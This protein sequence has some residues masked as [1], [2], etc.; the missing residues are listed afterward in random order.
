MDDSLQAVPFTLACCA[1]YGL[2]SSTVHALCCV[3]L[4]VVQAI[5]PYVV[6]AVLR[7]VAFTASRYKSFI[8]LQVRAHAY[9]RRRHAHQPAGSTLFRNA[10]CL[11]PQLWPY[12]VDDAQFFVRFP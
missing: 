1:L 10:S 4:V 3:A 6:C 9:T 11:R 12:Q 2:L 7:G 5:R 8:D